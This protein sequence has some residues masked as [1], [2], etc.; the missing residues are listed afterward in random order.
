[1]RRPPDVGKAALCIGLLLGISGC[2]GFTQHTT[3]SAPWTTGSD[4]ESASPPGLFSW[5]HRGGAQSGATPASPAG[6]QE[7]AGRP[8][9]Y[10]EAGQSATNP[11]PETQSEWVARTFPRMNRLW[12]GTPEGTRPAAPDAEGVTWTNR[13]P[14]NADAGAVASTAPRSD[15]AIRPTQGASLSAAARGADVAGSRPRYLDELPLSATPPPVRSPRASDPEVTA[16]A[17]SEAPAPTP[18]PLSSADDSSANDGARRVSYEPQDASAAAKATAGA[19]GSRSAADQAAA[20]LPQ[21]GDI[22]PAPAPALAGPQESAT[23]AVEG[24]RATGSATGLPVAAGPA[25]WVAEPPASLDTRV[26][27]VPPP[28]APPVQRTPPAPPPS[29]EEG[30]AASPPA[31]P[32]AT[33][34]GTENAAEATAPATVTPA[35]AQSRAPAVASGQPSLAASGQSIYASP[36]PMAPAQPRHHFLSWLFHDDDDATVLASTQSPLAGAPRMYSSPQ[37]VLPTGQGTAACDT[38]GNA[39]KKPCF[40]KV[41][42]HDWKNS[43]GSSGDDCGHGGVCASAQ[44]NAAACDTGT[45]TPKKPCFLK[46]WIHDLKNGHGS[47]NGDCNAG[48]VYPSP[49]SNLT[50]CETQGQA[51]PRSRV[52]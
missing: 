7:T 12:N 42:I 20:S 24:N 5:W 32:V 22:L 38:D 13:L 31:P 30:A 46:V 51:R 41:W 19:A 11:W 25:A 3:G 39:P 37:N 40:L 15:G 1:M 10:S 23:P 45:A 33:P 49:Q 26:A 52:S 35:P 16:P 18:F 50:A 6:M 29:G 44:T 8:Q 4:G 47:A 17:G 27:Q 14:E 36:P 2:A 48:A 43:H 9:G 34:A 21:L 28:P